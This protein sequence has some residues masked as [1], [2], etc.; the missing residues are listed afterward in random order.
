MVRLLLDTCV[1]R[2]CLHQ[3][4]PI[5]DLEQLKNYKPKI[6]VSIPD[7]A[8]AELTSQLF[9]SQIV[10]KDWSLRI[11]QLDDVLDPDMPICPS[12][13]ELSSLSGLIEGQPLYTNDSK[14][15]YRAIWQSMENAQSLNDLRKGSIY[16][17]SG[18]KFQRIEFDNLL[19]QKVMDEER[20]KFIRS[21]Q[22]IKILLKES[23]TPP[24]KIEHLILSG[25]EPR[26]GYSS[27][28]RDK[29]DAV[30]RTLAQIYEMSLKEKNAYNPAARK[31][32]GD[33]IDWSLL[34]ALALPAIICTADT[35]FVRRIRQKKSKQLRLVITVEELN[36]HLM[37]GSLHVLVEE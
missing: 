36:Q 14:I 6:L 12:G 2:N 29:L 16:K 4:A 32:R 28:S 13:I 26:E 27:N 21:I 3:Y 34:F 1:I 30:L 18:G 8:L 22:Q 33:F 25:M 24:E 15:Y 17:D 7:P 31:R 23:G 20:E 10:F 35:K 11:H 37:N 5:P 9:N 19:I